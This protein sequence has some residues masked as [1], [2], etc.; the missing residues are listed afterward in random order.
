M[1]SQLL[2]VARYVLS[3]GYIYPAWLASQRHRRMESAGW[4][5]QALMGLAC[6]LFGQEMWLTRVDQAVLAANVMNIAMVVIGGAEVAVP[7]A[8]LICVVATKL[9]QMNALQ[10]GPL[11]DTLDIIWLSSGLLMLIEFVQRP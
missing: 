1:A 3:L 6:R 2:A 10:D 4:A 11:K 5:C 8:V 7:W 9:Y